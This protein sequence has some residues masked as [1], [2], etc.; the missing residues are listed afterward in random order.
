[1]GRESKTTKKRNSKSKVKRKSIT[2]SNKLYYSKVVGI[3]LDKLIED[4]LK[5]VKKHPKTVCYNNLLILNHM[6]HSFLF[7]T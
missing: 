4:E 5:D 2:Q 1:M 3:V 6:C 7:I